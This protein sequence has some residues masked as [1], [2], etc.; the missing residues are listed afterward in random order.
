MAKFLLFVL[1]LFPSLDCLA[2][3]SEEIEI[4]AKQ[5]THDKDNKRIFASGNVELIDKEF[6]IYAQR[7]FY[8]FEKKIISAKEKVRIFYSDGSI[9]TTDSI[10]TDTELENAKIKKSYLYIPDDE[11][12]FFEKNNKVDPFYKEFLKNTSKDNLKMFVKD[13]KR[14][15]RIAAN[16]AERISKFTEIFNE[17]IFT[18]CDICYN[19]KK[20]KY[21]PPLIQVKAKKIIHD[22]ENLV[23]KYYNSYIE[24]NGTPVFFTPYFSHPS[25]LVKRKSGFLTPKYYS[26][27][28]LGESFD[29]PYYY[30]IS[31]YED[32]TFTP[33]FSTLKN[34]VG[35]LEHRKNFK[36]GEIRSQFIGTKT[37]LK[38]RDKIRGYFNSKGG[39]DINENTRWQYS[40]KRT[41]DKNFL[42]S[43][44]YNYEDTLNSNLKIESFRKNNYYS[45]D[46]YWFQELRPSFKQSETPLITPRLRAKLS[47]EKEMKTINYSSDLEFLTLTKDKGTDLSK[48][49]ILNNIEYPTILND[50]SVIKFGGHLNSSLYKIEN[51]HDPLIGSQKSSFFK[52]RFY[53][54]FTFEYSKPFYK[55]NKVS[56]QIFNPKVLIVAGANDGNNLHIPN[57]D[58]SN[59]DLD[60]IDLFQ[61]NRL[62][63]NDRLT[64]GTRVDYGFSYSNQNLKKLSISD[65]SIGQSYRIKKE[66]YQPLNSGT[67]NYFSNIVGSFNI[68]PTNRIKLK[69]FLS[70]DPTN[71]NFSRLLSSA[72]F[73]EDFNMFYI[74]HLYS[75]RTEGIEITNLDKRNQMQLGFSSKLSKFWRFNGSSTFDLV[76]NIKFL[77]WNSKVIYEDECFGLSFSW[78]RQYTYNTES[79]TSNSFMVLFSIKKL[80][81]N[82]I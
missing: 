74:N 67:N 11:K 56:K 72:N 70:I 64:N 14:Y 39:F 17:A 43:Y 61:R 25:P 8:N 82:D 81:Q 36:N 78:N 37:K 33:K 49:F 28:F 44:K 22:K 18:A 58:S 65:I 47:S 6:K 13:E 76:Q 34:P 63:G 66:A 48:I 50:G 3:K 71:F 24:F 51:Y 40:L 59:Y 54:Q 9:L 7:V 20:K 42:Q 79:P 41:T 60:F 12:K 16:S 5:F 30:P 4:N 55:K 62:S 38:E 21:D 32:I 77:N 27:V 15:V 73:G 35:Y 1:S 69:S 19:D 75:K 29:I 68:R 10:T 23:M 53:P 31:D 46:S 80:M 2:T 52:G 45:L 26:N 57:E